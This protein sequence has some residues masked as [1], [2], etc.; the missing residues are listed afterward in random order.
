[1]LKKLTHYL[2][3]KKKGSRK[4]VDSAINMNMKKK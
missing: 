3:N 1:M 2:K 4:Q